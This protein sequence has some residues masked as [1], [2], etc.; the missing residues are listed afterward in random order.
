MT[1]MP[2]PVTKGGSDLVTFMLQKGPASSDCHSSKRAHGV[3][4]VQLPW[5]NSLAED[6]EWDYILLRTNSCT[7]VL[8]LYQ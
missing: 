7:N 2:T 1:T 4:G 6:G 5:L 8:I 3:S